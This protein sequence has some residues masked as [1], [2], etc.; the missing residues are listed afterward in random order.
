MVRKR[1]KSS[2]RQFYGQKSLI[3]ERGQKR[4]L[5]VQDGGGG[6][7]VWGMISWPTLGHSVRVRDRLSSYCG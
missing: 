6:V 7:M 4:M 3:D 2:E 1:K 5:T